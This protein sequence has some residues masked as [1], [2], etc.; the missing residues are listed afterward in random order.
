MMMTDFII[1]IFK[2]IYPFF[3]IFAVFGIVL[4][5]KE[6]KWTAFDS[7]LIGMFVIFELL[8][9]FLPWLFYGELTTSRRYLLIG[10]PLYF[11]FA[12]MGFLAVWNC[13]RK[14]IAW[15]HIATVLLGIMVCVT[16]YNI[17]SPVLKEFTSSKK[18]MERELTL[19]AADWIRQDWNARSSS[20]IPWLKCDEYQSG[21]RP[22]VDS[23]FQR[24]GYLCGGQQ[25]P[26]FMKNAGVVPDYVVSAHQIQGNELFLA[27]TLTGTER[28]LFIYKK[29]GKKNE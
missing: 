13:S 18:S 4:R 6:R 1:S 19:V 24:I 5:L 20:R 16:L 15:K 26:A 11:P 27:Y 10:V 7:L 14:R 23:D 29:T 22:L 25:I 12:A 28:Q 21:K 9:A 3:F 8:T 17:Y 2:G